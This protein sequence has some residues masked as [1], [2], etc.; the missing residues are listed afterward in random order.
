MSSLNINT[1]TFEELLTLKDIG[2]ARAN[3]ILQ[4]RSRKKTITLTDLT[5]LTELT[6]PVVQALLES[7]KIN[8]EPVSS[9]SD[10]DEHEK[11]MQEYIRGLQEK[12]R[13]KDK[14]ISEY[15]TSQ[16][17]QSLD[18]N[19]QI[20]QIEER[21]KQEILQTREEFENKLDQMQSKF[22]FDIQSEIEMR[23]DKEI[24]WSRREKD[25][26]IQME[27][28]KKIN[29]LAPDSIYSKEN[30]S[31]SV[32]KPYIVDPSEKKQR[33]TIEG[34]LTPKM[35]TFD[36]KSDWRPYYTQFLH[37]AEICKWTDKQRI[38]NLIVCLRDKALKFYSSRHVKVKA[39][40]ADLCEKLNERFGSKDLPHIL[41]RQLQEIKQGYEESL[42]E[43]ADKI[44][45]LA[46][47]GYPNSPDSFIH[48]VA[49]DSFLRGCVEKKEAL[50]AM[51]KNPNSLEQATQYM[52]SAITNQKMI[53]GSKKSNEI[54]RV[55]FEELDHL[56]E[57]ESKVRAVYKDKS[58]SQVLEARVKK[59]EDDVQEIKKSLGQIVSLLKNQDNRRSRSP[60]RSPERRTPE[61]SECYS[62]GII[63]HFASSCPRRSYGRNR[64]PSPNRVSEKPL[65]DNGLR[66]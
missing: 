33:S 4:E 21:H 28:D 12:V 35:S 3:A 11:E 57:P 38:D 61:N 37:I 65:N 54:K 2:K 59:T 34:P 30:A 32:S 60:A 62:C 48:I 10:A 47:D 46:T 16:D 29:L 8:F 51:D 9:V 20:E 40:F 55:T 22:Q 18:V 27:M 45:E 19:K 1:A 26:L 5:S 41:R 64:S 24:Y 39:T 44:Q 15:Q 52:K 42:E 58:D 43:F 53:L 13:N 50:V 6:A 31:K 56:D 14:Q 49:V 25:L 63:G 66:K 23:Q 36:G 7:G 17:K